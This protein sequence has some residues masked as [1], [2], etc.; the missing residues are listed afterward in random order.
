M[1]RVNQFVFN[2]NG[3]NNFSLIIIYFTLKSIMIL[4]VLSYLQ[5]KC[6]VG[7]SRDFDVSF[8]PPE[9]VAARI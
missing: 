6:L 3:I 9:N 5:P 2:F 4:G 7:W 1:L 8:V